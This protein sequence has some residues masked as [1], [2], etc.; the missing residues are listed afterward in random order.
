ML[1]EVLIELYVLNKNFKM[2]VFL[3]EFYFYVDVI[4]IE[5]GFFLFFF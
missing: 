1:Y 3:V 4:D 2:E 5:E